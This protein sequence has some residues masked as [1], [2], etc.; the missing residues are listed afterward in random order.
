MLLGIIGTITVILVRKR[1]LV[2]FFGVI[3]LVGVSVAAVFSAGLAGRLSATA[4]LLVG[5][6]A[7]SVCVVVINYLIR[8]RDFYWKSGV[9]KS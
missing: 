6:A 8:Y 2:I 1:V 3:I 4:L 5:A 9:S 7:D